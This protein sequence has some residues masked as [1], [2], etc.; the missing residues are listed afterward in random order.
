M[1]DTKWRKL[2]TSIE[3]AGIGLS[4]MI[5]KFVDHPE[6]KVMNFPSVASLHPPKPYIDTPEFGP[7]ELRSIE[8]LD[9]PAV[10]RFPRPNKVPARE[11]AQDLASAG[12]VLDRLNCNA[13]SEPNSIRVIGYSR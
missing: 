11:V 4:Q 8:W 6:P 9:I 3:E 7:I 13:V 10:A 5:V 1:S 12:A 2:F